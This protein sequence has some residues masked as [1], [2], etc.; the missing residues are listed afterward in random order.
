MGNREKHF[1]VGTKN[2]NLLIFNCKILSHEKIRTTF[3]RR[4][5]TNCA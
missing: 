3:Y 5:R 4:S 2:P 1:K